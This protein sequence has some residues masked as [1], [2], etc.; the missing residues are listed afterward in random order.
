MPNNESKEAP[1]IELVDLSKKAR[2]ERAERAAAKKANKAATKAKAPSSFKERLQQ[3][4]SAGA[5]VAKQTGSAIGTTLGHVG[6]HTYRAGKTGFNV[7]NTLAGSPLETSYYNLDSMGDRARTTRLGRFDVKMQGEYYQK[8]MK[9]TKLPVNLDSMKSAET[10]QAT[11]GANFEK[12]Y[13]GLKQMDRTKLAEASTTG[14]EN[15]HK[16]GAKFQRMRTELATQSSD[17]NALLYI[18]ELYQLKREVKEDL[19]VQLIADLK[20]VE[21]LLIDEDAKKKLKEEMTTAHNNAAETFEDALTSDLKKLHEAA[22]H[23]RDRIVHIARLYQYGPASTK[24]A[25]ELLTKSGAPGAT[26]IATGDK[27]APQFASIDLDKLRLNPDNRYDPRFGFR[28]MTGVSIVATAKNSDERYNTFHMQL[29]RRHPSLL[30]FRDDPLGGATSWLTT[31]DFMYY[32]SLEDNVK[33]DMMELAERVKAGG[34]K[35]ITMDIT[36]DDPKHARF[37]AQKAY[38]ACL[39]TGFDPKNVTININGV[40]QSLSDIAKKGDEEARK[41]LH[42]GGTKALDD[43][44]ETRTQLREEQLQKAITS[45]KREAETPEATSSVAPGTGSQVG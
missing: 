24:R 14:S 37:L 28:T 36:H 11:R 20:C 27:S 8:F 31:G 2:T 17:F 45:A 6:I 13:S 10:Y 23:E 42:P 44:A 38:A 39:E 22:Q 15:T 29:P 21:T 18:D 1:G 5:T 12:F 3:A 26:V 32:H 16:I 43:L 7:L 4:L 40:K 25:I 19:R 30:S 9:A 41:G 34:F 35:A 33:S